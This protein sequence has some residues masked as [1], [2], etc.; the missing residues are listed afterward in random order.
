[1]APRPGEQRGE[2]RRDTRVRAVN[3]YGGEFR[4]GDAYLRDLRKRV[5]DAYLELAASEGQRRPRKG[6]TKIAKQLQVSEKSVERFVRIWEEEQR[7][8]P[9][10][11]GTMNLEK[12]TPIHVR[13][14]K[15]LLEEEKTM[16]L[17]EIR[18]MMAVDLEELVEFP[19]L[20]E[21][22]IWRVISRDLGLSKKQVSQESVILMLSFDC[23]WCAAIHQHAPRQG[24]QRR[25][26]RPDCQPCHCQQSCVL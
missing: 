8:D 21:P 2:D 25:L 3:K 6:Y 16:Y 23:Q 14:I 11:R 4:K 22:T 13:Y 9:L 26:T 20:S 19:L 18:E 10:E 17:W 1:M 15:T 12:V 7:V 5:V 24:K